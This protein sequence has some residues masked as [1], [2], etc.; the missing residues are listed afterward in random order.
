MDIARL[1]ARI[2]HFWEHREGGFPQEAVDIVAETLDQLTAGKIRAASPGGDGQWHAHEWVKKAVLLHF[3]MSPMR[4]MEAGALHFFD[5]VDVQGRWP[6]KGVRVVPPATVRHG[7]HLEEGVVLMPC[8]INIGARVGTGT[9]IDTWSTVG[10]CAQV[11]SKCHISGGV[12]IGGV[13][14]PLQATPVII[15]DKCFIGARCE[16]AEGVIVREGAVLAMGCYVG[17]S[18]RLYDATRK[19]EIE[20]GEIPAGAVVV[21]GTLPAG[22]GSH[23]T[24]AL[25][26]KKYRDAG[27]DAKTALNQILR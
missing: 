25:I 9:M 15:E 26:I 10:S 7:A 4:P 24:Y 14:E 20:R 8:Y 6:G 17:K 19:K 3:R 16:V 5:K 21:P 22:D 18:S 27:T 2:D 1:E 11:G 13:L 12:G 23:S